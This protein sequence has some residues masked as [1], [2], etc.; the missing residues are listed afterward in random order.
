MGDNTA[1][2]TK[3]S[4][5]LRVV[6]GG[7]MLLALIP[8]GSLGGAQATGMNTGM[9]AA[10]FSVAAQATPAAVPDPDLCAYLRSL[11]Q[12]GDGFTFSS[13]NPKERC[14]ITN[15]GDGFPAPIDDID[16]V[17]HSSPEI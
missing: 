1:Y 17:K 12:G 9:G 3:H 2:S 10:P 4:P 16:V 15:D 7:V 13:S 5:W 14:S 8:L 11:T 6:I